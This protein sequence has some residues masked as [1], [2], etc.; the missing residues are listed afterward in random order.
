[1]LDLDITDLVE[2]KIWIIM[3]D[4]LDFGG[5]YDSVLDTPF[6]T[7]LMQIYPNTYSTS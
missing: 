3:I 6:L 5:G 1:M 4:T 2:E 7:R